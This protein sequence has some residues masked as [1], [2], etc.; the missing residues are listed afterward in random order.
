MDVSSADRARPYILNVWPKPPDLTTQTLPT[1]YLGMLAAKHGQALQL[2]SRACGNA[3]GG[4][5]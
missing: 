3:A 4:R 1:S 2:A 5:A